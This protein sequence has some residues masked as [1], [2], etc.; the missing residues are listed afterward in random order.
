[1]A[2]G[3]VIKWTIG[4]IAALA[5]LC[6]GGI[7][8]VLST[9]DLNQFKAD[10]ETNVQKA[11]G[12]KLTLAGDVKLQIGLSPALSVESVSFANAEWG[13]Q[14]NLASIDRLEV[15]VAV[16]PLLRGAVNIKRLILIKPEILIETN[17]D[18]KSN[19]D[20]GDAEK[21]A[22]SAESSPKE[23]TEP[24]SGQT[25]EGLNIDVDEFV[26][27][28]ARFTYKDGQSGSS[29]ELALSLVRASLDSANKLTLSVTGAYNGQPFEV[30]GE[31]G[32]LEAA[33]NPKADWPLHIT[34]K[35]GGAVV[36]VEGAVQDLNGLAGIALAFSVEGKSL[37]D[38]NAISGASLPDLGKYALSGKLAD[39]GP[40][41]F[42]ISGLKGQLGESD[43]SGEAA[44]DMGGKRPDIVLSLT[45][46]TLDLRPFLPDKSEKV[47]KPKSK[48]AAEPK[49]KSDRVLPNDPLPADL[50]LLADAKGDIKIETVQLQDFA[51]TGILAAFA[52]KNGTLDVSSLKAAGGEGTLD[53]TLKAAA[54]GKN[55]D[56]T[57]KA[58]LDQLNIGGLLGFLGVTE[59]F[60]GNLDMELDFAGR[61]AS[62]R[63]IMGGLD[64]FL[65][66][67]VKDG[68]LQNKYLDLL[69]GDM[70][71]GFLRMINPVA[72][73]KDYTK[74]NCLIARLN[75]VKGEAQTKVM[76]MDTEYMSVVGDGTIDFD[77]ER[78]NMS[79]DPMPKKGVLSGVN[80]DV[81]FSMSELAQPFALGGTLASPK[82]VLDRTKAVLTL[83]K[84]V[85]G[86]LLFGPA[87]AAAALLSTGQSD[88]NPCE[89]AAKAAE[90]GTKYQGE[91]SEKGAAEKAADTVV[92]EIK[93]VGKGLKNLF[94]Q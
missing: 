35:A 78:L 65:S 66:M 4:I 21:T 81:S 7:A 11:T 20:F 51:L 40:K 22:A 57:G 76:V 64:G 6:V 49:K 94:S 59:A 89:S 60:K 54:K 43:V 73:K 58:V 85:G 10:I 71:T 74:V 50:L 46:K 80:I 87:G 12:R 28:D 38:L 55:L 69:G 92:N 82:L 8:Y 1:M 17:K 41:A 30:N 44:L 18:G 75:V 32:G 25:G 88:E 79:L 45:S 34:A 3:R 52:L 70:A 27:Q 19:L 42:K 91:E 93:G 67:S 37:A 33:M 14:P 9:L 2:K 48:P 90:Q 16:L 23:T 36:T 61:G 72:E 86:A 24:S 53:M 84:G 62:V 39:A 5:V 77:T 47:E 29:Q 15:Q 13:S 31:T 56:L 26:L 63:D 68:Q 83:G